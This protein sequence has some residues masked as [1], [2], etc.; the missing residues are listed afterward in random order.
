M[1]NDFKL[2]LETE[3]EKDVKSLL[4]KIPKGH[5]KLF[6]GFKVKFTPGN[7]LK[8]D[9]ESIGY[10]HK[11]KIVVAAPFHYSRSMV[12]AHEIAHMVFEHLMTSSLKKE[13]SKLLK[14]TLEDQKKSQPQQNR[15]ALDQNDEEIFCMVYAATYVKHPPTTYLNPEWQNFIKH[16]VPN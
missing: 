13:W 16:K 5:Q 11:N 12:L 2:F 14:S 8:N 7:T 3:E 9:K 6:D 10:I 15:S 1:N 4:S